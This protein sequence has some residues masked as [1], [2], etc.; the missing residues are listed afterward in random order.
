MENRNWVTIIVVVAL[1]AMTIT[2]SV[3][4][5]QQNGKLSEAQSKLNIME[6]NYNAMEGNVSSLSSDVSSLEGDLSTLETNLGNDISTLENGITGLQGDVSNLSGNVS[7]LQSGLSSL[8]GDVSDVES[9]LNSLT[10]DFSALNS[11]FNALEGNVSDLQGDVSGLE[12]NVSSLEGAVS[13]LESYDQAMIN[14]ASMIEPSIVMIVADLG[15]GWFGSGT[16]VIVSSDGWIL[17][18]WHVLDGAQE[19]IIVLSTGETFDGVMPYEEHNYL[20]LAMVKIDSARNN[21]V[22]ATLGSSSDTSVGEDVIA[23]GFPYSFNMGSPVTFTRGVVSA[24]RI[25]WMDGF[26]YIQTDASINPGNS[27]G[28]LV[29]FNGEVIGINTWKYYL[30][31]VDS[32]R[33]F[34]EGLNFAIP[35]DDAIS[36]LEDVID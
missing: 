7:G 25:D 24:F 3:L 35:I 8:E 12:G 15:G 18:N 32:E 29:N 26:E 27:G 22:P 17:T 6:Y 34:A 20:D 36:F 33:L 31:T 19:I 11:D 21:F 30:A 23:V 1:V 2:N 10:G 16:G 4:Y 14:V 28:A 13:D 5:F 9:G